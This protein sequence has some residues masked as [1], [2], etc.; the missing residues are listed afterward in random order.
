MNVPFDINEI[1]NPNDDEITDEVI[2]RN[3]NNEENIYGEVIIDND[4]H[5][6]GS[7][8]NFEVIKVDENINQNI[9]RDSLVLSLNTLCT[10]DRQW[11]IHNHNR[12]CRYWNDNP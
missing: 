1:E 5:N 11:N 4:G 7:D 3:D 10:V 12:Q 6:Q 8:P 9:I 2:L